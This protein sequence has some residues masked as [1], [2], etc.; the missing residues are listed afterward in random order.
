M[1]SYRLG[2]VLPSTPRQYLRA[3]YSQ[4]ASPALIKVDIPAYKV[5]APCYR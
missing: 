3:D 5:V 1:L 2:T 4:E